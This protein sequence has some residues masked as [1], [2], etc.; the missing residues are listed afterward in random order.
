MTKVATS[1]E[2]A[3][4]SILRCL[5]IYSKVMEPFIRILNVGVPVGLLL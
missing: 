5:N 1:Q 2:R 3:E 4:T